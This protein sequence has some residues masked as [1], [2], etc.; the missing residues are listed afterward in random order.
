MVS[1]CTFQRWPSLSGGISRSSVRTCLS[2]L[3]RRIS[4]SGRWNVKTSR[5]RASG[6][7]ALVNCVFEPVD[8]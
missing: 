4:S 6:S 7:K 5:L 8:S 1:I 3:A 2:S